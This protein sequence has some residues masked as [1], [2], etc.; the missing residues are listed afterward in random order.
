MLAALSQIKFVRSYYDAAWL[1]GCCRR[2]CCVLCY[3]RTWMFS[4]RDDEHAASH[5]IADRISKWLR[6]N[7]LPANRWILHV[8]F[9]WICSIG[10]KLWTCDLAWIITLLLTFLAPWTSWETCWGSSFDW[11]IDIGWVKGR[12]FYITLWWCYCVH[13]NA[14]WEQ[15]I[16]GNSLVFFT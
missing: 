4:L 3:L 1:F 7:L 12:N 8:R 14:A 5:A 16:I 11:R 10:L 13:I 2:R 6:L 15:S 9:L